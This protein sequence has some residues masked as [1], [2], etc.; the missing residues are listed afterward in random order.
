MIKKI[1]S[2]I[3]LL[4][5]FYSFSQIP[6]LSNK[7]VFSILTV[8]IANE[9]HTLYGHTALRVKDPEIGFDVVY[10]YG[11][12][13]FSTPNFLLKFTKGDLKYYAAV[14][15]YHQFEYSYQVE[16]RSI[17]EQKLNLTLEEKQE[18][19]KKLNHSVFSEEKFYTYKFIDRNCTT[20]VID[21]INEVLNDKPIQ[22][23]L[24]KNESYR[25]VLYNYQKDLFY[26]NFGIN[27]IFGHRPDEQAK[28]LFLPLDLMKVL[29]TCKHNE[30][31]LAGKPETLFHVKIPEK[32]FSLFN[33]ILPISLLLIIIIV[34]NQKWLT[35]IYLTILSLTGLFL[36]TVSIYSEHR[37]VLWNY[38]ILLFNPLYLVV[39]FYYHKNN[40]VALKK[41]SLLNLVFLGI[42]SLYMFTKIHLLIISPILITTGIILFR[43][44]FQ[45]KTVAQ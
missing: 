20:K 9:S 8:D 33:S 4:Q 32:K 15:P 41:W 12:F 44:Y 22:N 31:P 39:I 37:E 23:T 24:H 43:N 29:E 16:N 25:E 21:I 26:L 17:Y 14:Y 1:L 40:S 38:N 3:V 6:V 30:K 7:A 28:V 11:M 36:L 18:L 45:K 35:T 19:F 27:V 34:T 2:L 5:S 10:N 13:D 42:Y